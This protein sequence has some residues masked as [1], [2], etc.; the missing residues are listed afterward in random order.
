VPLVYDLSVYK[1]LL[2]RTAKL[3]CD[4]RILT[5]WLFFRTQIL[6][7]GS[8]SGAIAVSLNGLFSNHPDKEFQSED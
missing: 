7:V 3:S 1:W 8:F 2:F 5:V 6:A 4:Y